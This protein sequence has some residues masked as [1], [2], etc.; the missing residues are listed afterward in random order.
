ME[1]KKPMLKNINDFSS[2][3]SKNR[4]LAKQY[5]QRGVIFSH[6]YQL[7]QAL[8]DFDNAISLWPTYVTAIID[9][10][11]VLSKMQ[12]YQEALAVL[13]EAERI[14]PDDSYIF[15][16]R[17]NINFFLEKYEDATKDFEKYLSIDSNSVYRGIWLFLAQSHIDAKL[18]Q[19]KLAKYSAAFKSS[20]W[21]WPIIE[22][23]LGKQDISSLL[24]SLK[25]KEKQMSPGEVCE[26]YFY[27][28][29]WFLLKNDIGKAIFYFESSLAT[30]ASDFLEFQYSA[31][32][33]KR[34]K[35]DASIKI[36]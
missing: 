29:Q 17:G 1:T 5:R 16:E 24:K 35:D 3:L 31:L 34:I 36:H 18:G 8:S 26:A 32:T 2:E 13:D 23:Y 6:R 7:E 25:D 28:A 12:N 22:L 30:E 15:R 27:I 10:A 14:N 19:E 33:L 21:P 9:K 4:I 20:E 11:V